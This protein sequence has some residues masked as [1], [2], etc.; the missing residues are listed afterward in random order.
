MDARVAESAVTSRRESWL[1][2]ERESGRLYDRAAV[3]IAAFL[4]AMLGLS[5][6]LL[7]RGTEPGTLAVA[8]DHRAAAGREPDPGDRA[9]GAVLAQG[10]D[11]PRGARGARQRPAAHPPRRPV[12]RHRRGADRPGRD[13]RLA[14]V[15]KRARILVLQPRPQD[16]R[17]YRRRLRKRSIG[18]EVERVA[19]ETQRRWPAI[20]RN[21]LTQNADRRSALRRGVRRLQIYI[22][23]SQR[24]DHLHRSGRTRQI[25]TPRAGQSV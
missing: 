9:D 4:V 21:I 10:R 12:L 6:W 8:A 5:F 14:A 17:K 20:W 11:A 7:R 22:A 1:Q 25:R 19:A 23:V 3:V 24:S 16:A 13:L 2:R 18:Y 15:P